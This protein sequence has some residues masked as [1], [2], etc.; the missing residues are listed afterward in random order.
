[1]KNYQVIV[2]CHP[3]CQDYEKPRV[4]D[5][6]CTAEEAV[7][8]VMNHTDRLHYCRIEEIP[9]VVGVIPIDDD[10]CPACLVV[11]AMPG[12]SHVIIED[13]Q[14]RMAETE[15]RKITDELTGYRTKYADQN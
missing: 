6:P 2:E 15:W 12:C 7:R 1:M 4:M 5:D 9:N 13:H 14:V 11:R 3:D 10:L 8:L